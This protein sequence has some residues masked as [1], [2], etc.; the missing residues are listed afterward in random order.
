MMPATDPTRN[1]SG[2]GP[3]A[4]A[5]RLAR[6]VPGQILVNTAA[7]TL[8]EELRM[9]EDWRVLDISC[10]R[11]SLL[12]VLADR[13]GL[14]TPPV[15]VEAARPMLKA[16]QRDM[17]TEGGPAVDLAQGSATSLP[18]SSESFQLIIAGHSF[19]RLSDDELRAA[20]REARRA[21]MPGGLLL[22]WEFAPTG[23][24]LL[25]R[26]NRWVLA[27]ESPQV[28]L[29]GYGELA[30]LARACGFDWV[31][32]ARLRPFL[33]PPIPRVSLVMGRAPAGWRSRDIE[34]HEALQHDPR[35][36]D[37]RPGR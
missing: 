11:A 35:E 1:E 14:E 12:R 9:R 29:R 36:S 22:A 34:G 17:A 21:L 13:A 4:A 27:R 15:G 25:D 2:R 10:G 31:E 6:S 23:S 28:R 7:F 33:L 26:W 3:L 19:R 16:A 32:N 20:L 37:G 30:T 18:I 8:P 5:L 24:A